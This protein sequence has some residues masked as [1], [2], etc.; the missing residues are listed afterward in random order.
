MIG[1]SRAGRVVV[2]GIM[3]LLVVAACGDD[4]ADPERFCEI[5]AEFD[6]MG[7]PFELPPDEVRELLRRG[8]DLLDE[9]VKVAPD[10]IRLSV[11][12]QVDSFAPFFD[13]F[14]AA[15]FD[16]AQMDEAEV[17]VVF[18]TAFSGESGAAF[19][20]IEVWVDANCST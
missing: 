6:Q 2:V 3:L 16:A 12:I 14:E 18:E 19:E 10:E 13:L 5:D 8:R 11:E 1:S 17:E 15:D 7:D 20:A 4:A 9:S